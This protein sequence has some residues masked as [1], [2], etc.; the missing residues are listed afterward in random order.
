MSLHTSCNNRLIE[1][2][3][4]TIYN[5]CLDKK[6]NYAIRKDFVKSAVLANEDAKALC[7]HMI[8]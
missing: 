6:K 3:K 5:K 4:N 1:I 7:L 8:A 2:E